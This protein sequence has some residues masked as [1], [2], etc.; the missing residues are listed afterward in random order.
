M[1][2]HVIIIK[3]LIHF[4]APTLTSVF[5]FYVTLYY[6]YYYIYY[7]TTFQRKMVYFL[8]YYIFMTAIVTLQIQILNTS[9]KKL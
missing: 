7:S 9:H 5:P 6:Y 4:I 8:P 2:S 3:H 1:E